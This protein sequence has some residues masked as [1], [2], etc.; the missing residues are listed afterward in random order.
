[1]AKCQQKTV[2]LHTTRNLQCSASTLIGTASSVRAD[3][4]VVVEDDDHVGVQEA[5]MVHRLVGHAA[6][7]GTVADDSDAVVVPLLRAKEQTRSAQGDTVSIM[8]T[9][10]STATQA[11]GAIKD[12]HS[13]QDKSISTGE[14]DYVCEPCTLK[15]RP[16]AMPRMD[17]IDVELCP[18]P[19]GS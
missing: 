9:Y 12:V 17:E 3:L 19:K 13:Q 5:G 16:T 8:Q 7:D 11:T 15:S 10:C 4:L 6:R 1:M 18:A 14:D 2:T